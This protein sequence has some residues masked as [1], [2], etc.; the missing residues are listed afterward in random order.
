[1]GL[2]GGRSRPPSLR[3]PKSATAKRSARQAS[4]Q[5][6]LHTRLTSFRGQVHDLRRQRYGSWERTVTVG[7]RRCRRRADPCL[8]GLPGQ[9][10]RLDRARGNV[11]GVRIQTT[12]Q[13]DGRPRVP[14]MR[15][16]MVARCFGRGF[17]ALAS[18]RVRGRARRPAVPLPASR[19]LEPPSSAGSQRWTQ[20]SAVP[21]ESPLADRRSRL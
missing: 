3:L 2:E 14:R 19:R 18:E 16:P 17:E 21:N 12:D 1:M 11:S 6:Q 13:V 4:L 15:K 20:R 5:L 10:P 9:A 7:A 8:P